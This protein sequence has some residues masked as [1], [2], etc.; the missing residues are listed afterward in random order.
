MR[1]ARLIR[2]LSITAHGLLALRHA[3]KDT[4]WS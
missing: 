3:H 2:M 1:R 4:L